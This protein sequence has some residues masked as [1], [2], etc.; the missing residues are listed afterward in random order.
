MNE[1][2]SG[3]GLK[4]CKEFVELNGG[5]IWVTNNEGQGTRFMFTVLNGDNNLKYNR[6]IV[7]AVNN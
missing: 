1:K 5:N 3:L 7:L 2:G 4:L 6:E